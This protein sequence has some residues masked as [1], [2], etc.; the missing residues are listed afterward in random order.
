[1]QFLINILTIHVTLSWIIGFYIVFVGHKNTYD[2]FGL[3]ARIITGLFSPI[4]LLKILFIKV[5]D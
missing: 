2:K 3:I 1:M 5:K 4:L